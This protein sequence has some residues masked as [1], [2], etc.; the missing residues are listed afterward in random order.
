MK[1]PAERYTPSTRTYRGLP[2]LTYPFHDREILVTACGRTRTPV[3]ALSA[4]RSK[5]VG[6]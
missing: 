5:G 2:D 3:A 1:C 4:R 6:V